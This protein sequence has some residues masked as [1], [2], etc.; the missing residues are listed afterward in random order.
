[1]VSKDSG[2]SGEPQ[3]SILIVIVGLLLALNTRSSLSLK[4]VN[5]R[6]SAAESLIPGS[7]ESALNKM[8]LAGVKWCAVNAYWRWGS[9][10][11]SARLADRDGRFG[12]VPRKGICK[13]RWWEGIEPEGSGLWD[14]QFS[15]LG[16]GVG[17]TA[18]R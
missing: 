13:G 9:H 5:L 1:M 17:G 18:G 4:L 15:G 6:L 11:Y 8:G 10:T 16:N 12:V 14:A 3:T 2:Q 7:P